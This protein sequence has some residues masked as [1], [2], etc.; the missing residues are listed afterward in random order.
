RHCLA[1]ALQAA[2]G[3]RRTAAEDEWLLGHSRCECGEVPQYKGRQK[4][5]VQTW[6]GTITLERGYF[7]CTGCGKG[8][9]PLYPLDEAL[10]IQGRTRFS[11]GVQQGVCLLG[12]QMPFVQASHTLEVLTGISISPKQAERITEER[13]LVLE[14]SLNE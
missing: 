4:R 5:T 6:V 13:G 12:V 10:G 11:D 7:H 3:E 2:V 1:A 8:R 9:Y 14:Q